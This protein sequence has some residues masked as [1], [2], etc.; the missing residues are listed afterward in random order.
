MVPGVGKGGVVWV[1]ICEDL[2]GR[3]V[4]GWMVPGVGKRGGCL[5][6]DL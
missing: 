6:G 4:G 2:P 3:A 5:G 1:V